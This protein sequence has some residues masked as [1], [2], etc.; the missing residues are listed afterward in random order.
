LEGLVIQSA[1]LNKRIFLTLFMA[2]FASTLGVG[3]VVPL[4]PSY[5]HRMGASGLYIGAIFGV[6]SLSRSVFLPLFGRWSDRRGRKIFLAIGLLAYCLI[7][8]AFAYSRNIYDLLAIRF[9]HGAAAAAILPVAFAYVGEISP[10]NQEGR[11]MG[12][13]QIAL[14]SGLSA[15]PLLGG[16][17]NDILGLKMTFW[18]MGIL[19]FLAFC[20]CLLV[21]P[22]EQ[23][24]SDR[25][26]RDQEISYIDI[27]KDRTIATLFMQRICFASTIG[28]IWSFVP[29]MA[30]TGLGLNSSHTGTVLMLNTALS[31]LCLYPM[32][33]VADKFDKRIPMVVGGLVAA[34]ALYSFGYAHT[35]RDL[36]LVGAL[37]GLALGIADPAV[38]AVAVICGRQNKAMGATMGI[39]SLSHSLGMIVGP[40]LGGLIID[41]IS[42]KST[43]FFGT[44]LVVL[45]TLFLL[46]FIPST[47]TRPAAAP[48]PGA[49]PPVSLH[50]PEPSSPYIEKGRKTGPSVKI[51]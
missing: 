28:I 51:D 20:L 23:S 47:V 31:T 34:G 32:G 50:F 26:K 22:A 42:F 1:T 39:F 37:H 29:L 43:F 38:M 36:L 16:V 41:L 48:L 21:L 7:S 18:S 46:I 40:I 6:F 13:F 27:I 12:L 35:F 49:V 44:V 14:M 33:V 11:I 2:I 15:G 17:M 3:M 25:R 4:L 30:D 9:A 5:A 10:L 45:G 8:F 19:S 24:R